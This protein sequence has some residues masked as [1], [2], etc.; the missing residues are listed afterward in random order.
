M[1][2]AAAYVKDID[3]KLLQA[4]KIKEIGHA[5]VVS[6]FTCLDQQTN[7]LGVVGLSSTI[8]GQSLV[9]SETARLDYRPPTFGVGPHS[10][11]KIAH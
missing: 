10:L 2:R 7:A 1:T 3:M 5:L 4:V 9:G 8:F 11:G 6:G